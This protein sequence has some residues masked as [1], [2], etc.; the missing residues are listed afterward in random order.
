ML[1]NLRLKNTPVFLQGFLDG[2]KL[3]LYDPALRLPG[4]LYE[5]N[6]KKA[7]GL[8][9][10]KSL[11]N[12]SLTGRFLPE[13]KEVDIKR[14]MSGKLSINIWIFI[15]AGRITEVSG[16]DELR[17]EPA[18][19]RINER[20]RVGSIIEN[21]R[22]IRNNYCE[23]AMLCD[24]VSE[25]KIMINRVYEKIQIKDEFGE[26]MKIVFFDVERLDK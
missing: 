19:V 6:L 17:K 20:Y 15:R 14:E 26:D 18:V 21:W 4:F 13:L 1:R 23:V 25:A 16:V 5:H 7:T 2:E 12:F 8:D 22:N 3:R 24:N 10:Y 11:V 9:I